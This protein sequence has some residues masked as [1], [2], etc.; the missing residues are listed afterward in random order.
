MSDNTPTYDQMAALRALANRLTLKARDHAAEAKRRPAGDAQS[1][2]L[3]GL[4]EG[5]YKAALELADI[6]KQTNT[7]TSEAT[8][9]L[10]QP[11]G[12]KRQTPVASEPGP[13]SSTSSQYEQIPL[14]EV[15][16]L[17]AYANINPRD[18]VPNRDNTFVAIFSRWQPLSD[19]ERLEIL[20]Q[21]DP[22]IYVLSSGRNHDTSDP[23]VKFG[24]RKQ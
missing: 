17:L 18:V 22:R 4:A 6:L 23:F 2:Y 14:D 13:G 19:Q 20:K 5:Y 1:E 12:E 16:R 8:S 11:A 10:V 7:L 15:L 24:F 3:R 9:A 21:A